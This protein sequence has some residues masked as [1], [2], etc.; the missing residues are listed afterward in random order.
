MD[1]QTL[2]QTTAGPGPIENLRRHLEAETGHPVSLVET[3][4]SWVLLTQQHAYKL[5]K[6][7]HL[8]FVDFSTLA[9]RKHF[10]EEEL[11]LN[12]HLAPDLY[13]S[14]VP[15]C[16]S[17]QAPRIGGPGEP[18]DHAVCM[19]PFAPGALLSEQLG[20][21]T[22]LP[23]HLEDLARRVATFHQHAPIASSSPAGGATQC[24]LEPALSVLRQL[25]PHCAPERTGALESWFTTQAEALHAVW[26][27][28]QRDS[29][30]REC[31]GDLHLA[32][33]VPTCNAAATT[34]VC[35]CCASTRSIARWCV[36]WS[37]A[38]EQ[39]AMGP[40]PARTTLP[41]PSTWCRAPPADRAC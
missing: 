17:P 28:R 25:R 9:L 5:K 12:R 29:Q 18:I 13:L 4:I 7:V 37:L 41:A 20:A 8:P 30:V 24:V 39:A 16:G 32:N 2:P 35:R 26:A 1:A 15:I 38:Y 36:R 27:A 23:E 10:C 40:P 19:H 33:T 34:P 3:H 11:R 6:P 14:V 31:H 22:L 21:G